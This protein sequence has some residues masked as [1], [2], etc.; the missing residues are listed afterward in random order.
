[1]R[2]LQVIAGV[3]FLSAWIV[4][5][6]LANGGPKPTD[7]ATTVAAYYDNHEVKSMI[8]TLLIDGLAG[9]AIIAIAYNLWRYFTDEPGTAR[10]VLLWSG[11]GAGIASLLQMID[12]VTMSYRAA[13]GAS[14]DSV[15]TLF[16]VL[17]NGDTV[18]IALLA[19]KIASAS[20]LGR[21]TGLFPNWFAIAGLVFAPLLALSG[22]AFPF[23]SDALYASLTVTLIGLLA[24][25]LIV[26]VVVVRRTRRAPAPRVAPLAPG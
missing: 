14:A 10:Q 25:V 9:L 7:A 16:K 5:L 17:N 13:H 23:N 15:K 19:I 24:W 6:G 11:V 1:M 26:T 21:R 8:A 2:R 4:G 12:G 18:K 20:I 22:L 3:T